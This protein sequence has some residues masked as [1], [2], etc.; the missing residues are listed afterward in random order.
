MIEKRVTVGLTKDEV[1]ALVR[2][3]TR[4]GLTKTEVAGRAVSLLDIC[5]DLVDDSGRIV[6]KNPDGSD[7]VILLG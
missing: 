1:A 2:V 4:T 3:R 7:I 6:I 5:L